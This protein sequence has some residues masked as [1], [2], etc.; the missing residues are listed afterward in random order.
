MVERGAGVSLSF[1]MKAK[2]TG[3]D[4]WVLVVAVW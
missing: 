1:D 3:E 4:L 2:E